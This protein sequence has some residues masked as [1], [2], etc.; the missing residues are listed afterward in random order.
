MRSQLI[1]ILSEKIYNLTSVGFDKQ[2]SSLDRFPLK[3]LLWHRHCKQL[4]IMRNKN[5][6]K[7]PLTHSQFSENSNKRIYE[8]INGNIAFI[9]FFVLYFLM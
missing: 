5:V 2:R 9:F 6:S 7:M 8:R 4:K 3:F 1:S